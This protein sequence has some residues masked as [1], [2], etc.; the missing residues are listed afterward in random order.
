MAG[1]TKP[2]S[3]IQLI[4]FMAGGT[5]PMPTIQLLTIST[6]TSLQFHQKL[7]VPRHSFTSSISRVFSF[8]RFVLQFLRLVLISRPLLSYVNGVLSNPIQFLFITFRP[9]SSSLS[10]RLS[11]I[12][13]RYR[14]YF[15]D[16]IF[17]VSSSTLN[18]LSPHP[19]SLCPTPP[20]CC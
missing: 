18:L 3:M 19:R 5:K 17:S 12:S 11:F 8:L 1:G 20:P 10:Q 6:S 13:Y 9:T 15:V 14:L 16:P 4:N 2:T 7:V